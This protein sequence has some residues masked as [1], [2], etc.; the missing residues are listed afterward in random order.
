MQLANQASRLP[1]ALA[2]CSSKYGHFW[3]QKNKMVTDKMQTQGFKMAD[4]PT[5]SPFVFT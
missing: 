3:L 4:D 5:L 1:L 2:S